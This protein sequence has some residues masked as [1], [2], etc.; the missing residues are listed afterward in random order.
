VYFYALNVFLFL[1]CFNPVSFLFFFKFF[2]FVFYLS[3][4]TENGFFYVLTSLLFNCYAMTVALAY[5]YILAA[6]GML[7]CWPLD[8][9]GHCPAQLTAINTN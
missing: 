6:V 9:R 4:C 7:P 8:R 2:L 1:F 5:L 3:D